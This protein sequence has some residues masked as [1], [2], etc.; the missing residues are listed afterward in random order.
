MIQKLIS[1]KIV[2]LLL[3]AFV[4]QVTASTVIYCEM[5]DS[6][7]SQMGD[8][9]GHDMT[10]HGSHAAKQSDTSSNIQSANQSSGSCCDELNGC[11]TSGCS[12][13][14]C[15][16]VAF[17]TA[18]ETSE[19]RLLLTK[20]SSINQYLPFKTFSTLYRPPILS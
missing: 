13:N 1:L 11:T 10:G 19:P 9:S 15:V 4:G 5:M 2:V 7:P 20:I 16:P 8:H 12:M 6:A 14:G 17:I 3:L 18:N